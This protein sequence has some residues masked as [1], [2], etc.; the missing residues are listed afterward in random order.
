[1]EIVKTKKYFLIAMVFLL[2]VLV[3]PAA[4][5]ASLI[6]AETGPYYD[7]PL[8]MPGYY[9]KDPGDC[10]PFGPSQTI[11]GLREQGFPYPLAGLPANKPDPSLNALPIRI[12]SINAGQTKVY[13]SLSD[14]TSGGTVIRSYPGGLSR[15]VAFVEQANA[16]GSTFVRLLGGGWI[17]AQP[18]YSIPNWQGLEFFDSPQSD[19]GFTRWDGLLQWHEFLVRS[20]R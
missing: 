16:G 3:N 17:E 19:F 8:C 1:M 13:A 15:Y 12:A 7:L 6:Q 9:P 11:S 4:V 20:D 5:N 18:L 14:A 10:L 2:G